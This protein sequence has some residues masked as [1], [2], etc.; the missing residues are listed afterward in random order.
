[1]SHASH[2]FGISWR[3]FKYV[4][5]LYN[6]LPWLAKGKTTAIQVWYHLISQQ[7]KDTRRDWPGAES[8]SL[9]LIL[10]AP[11]SRCLFRLRYHVPMKI[12]A[13][14]QDRNRK[15]GSMD[16][17]H[18]CGSTAR[19]EKAT[20][21]HFEITELHLQLRQKPQENREK[22]NCRTIML[23]NCRLRN[24]CLIS[25]PTLA[26]SAMFP[27]ISSTATPEWLIRTGIRRTTLI[28]I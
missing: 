24:R 1:M 28:R 21:A 10:G 7:L 20:E 26:H 3:Q 11:N 4:V 23:R 16:R 18:E 22:G 25:T 17:S 15:I 14:R 13:E 27:G 8:W 6:K 5:D 12:Q 19:L 9:I 2:F